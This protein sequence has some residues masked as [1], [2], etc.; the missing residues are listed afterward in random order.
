MIDQA[1]ML[2]VDAPFITFDQPL[3][4]KAVYIAMSQSIN[5]VCH[6]GGFNLLLSFLGSIGSLMPRSGQEEALDCCYGANTVS[7]MM[8]GKAVCS[9]HQRAL[10]C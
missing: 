8:S 7:H 10:S 3:W 1:K 2:H 9:C 6:L 5:I 4:Q